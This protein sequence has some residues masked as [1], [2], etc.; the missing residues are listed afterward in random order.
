MMLAIRNLFPKY[1][2]PFV[3]GLGNRE[4]DAIAYR[5]AGI[6]FEN[7]FIVNPE[8]KVHHLIDAS[9]VVCYKAM[10]QNLE[11]FFPK[12]KRK[13]IVKSLTMELELQGLDDEKKEREKERDLGFFG[14][15][16]MKKG[17]SV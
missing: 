11:R 10:S 15:F 9:T 17:R 2:T 8:S 16:N 7:I 13:S 1:S 12:L 14:V 4:N 5:A 3:G 6:P